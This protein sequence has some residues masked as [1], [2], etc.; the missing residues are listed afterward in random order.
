[1]HLLLWFTV[2]TTAL[3]YHPPRYPTVS[4]PLVYISAMGIARCFRSIVCPDP[5]LHP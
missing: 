1:M 3:A 5:T 2:V 4:E